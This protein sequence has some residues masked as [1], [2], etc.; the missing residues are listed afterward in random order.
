MTTQTETFGL[1]SLLIMLNLL[2]NA[3]CYILFTLSVQLMIL[4]P[5]LKNGILKTGNGQLEP[6]PHF[7]CDWNS[8]PN[9]S[10]TPSMNTL[11]LMAR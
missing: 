4:G 11:S 5:C 3:Y 2:K 7:Q 10:I 8:V 6:S 1:V 9:S